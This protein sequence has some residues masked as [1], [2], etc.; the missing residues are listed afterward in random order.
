MSDLA[1]KV[2]P[3]HVHRPSTSQ[4]SGHALSFELATSDVV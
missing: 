4:A 3:A 1:G 2:G